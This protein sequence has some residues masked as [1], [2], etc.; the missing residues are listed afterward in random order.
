MSEAQIVQVELEIEQAQEALELGKALDRLQNNND[1]N[2]LINEQFLREEAIRLVGLKADPAMQSP[3]AKEAINN[4]QLAIS[5]LLAY[6]R[7]VFAMADQAE[8]AIDS[9]E[10]ALEELRIENIGGT[11]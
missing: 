9:A 7:K 1:F 11:A 2:K 5:G 10:E 8:R 3:E 6:F 4:Q